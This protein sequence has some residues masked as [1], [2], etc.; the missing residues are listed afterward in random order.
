M[1]YSYADDGTIT[2]SKR[3]PFCREPA[4]VTGISQVDFAKYMNGELLQDAFLTLSAAQR[5]MIHTGI[6]SKCWDALF[7]EGE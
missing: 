5:E 1:S 3:C 2:V 4:P 6:H 7:T